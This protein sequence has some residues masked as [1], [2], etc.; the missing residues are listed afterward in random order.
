L[1]AGKFQVP[2]GIYSKD[3]SVI[4][5]HNYSIQKSNNQQLQ[6]TR[7]WER[8]ACVSVSKKEIN[9]SNSGERER[10]REREELRSHARK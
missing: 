2:L 10:E 5:T 4:K 1:V 3:S 8:E 6:L 7:A 9:H